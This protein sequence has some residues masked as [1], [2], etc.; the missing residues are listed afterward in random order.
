MSVID[1]F[2]TAVQEILGDIVDKEQ[3]EIKRASELIAEAVAR[4]RVLSVF[5]TGGHSYMAGEEIFYRA[6]G[7]ACVNA[8]LDSGVSLIHGARRT[9]RIER[10]SGYAK[11]VLDGYG[12]EKDDVLLIVNNSGLNAVT[13]DA[14]NYAKERGVK[15]IGVSSLDCSKPVPADLPARHP[16]A[17]NLY[18]VVDIH[19]DTHVPFGDATVEVE[20]CDQKVAPAST[21]AIAF[22]L[23]SMIAGA[24]EKLVE[25]GVEP[26][27]VRGLNIPGGDEI[28]KV[29]LDRYEDR[30]KHL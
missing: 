14:A 3:D 4:D 8:V 23:Q 9:T 28:T 29:F 26:P 20:G 27:V 13:I 21:I 30:I 2:H 19:V 15:A 6:G 10:T 18:E 16:S 24:V 22:I 25:M 11:A 7:L 1:R 5:G 17:K 12:L